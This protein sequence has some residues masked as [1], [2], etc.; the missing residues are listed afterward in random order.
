MRGVHYTMCYMYCEEQQTGLHFLVVS[1]G[2]RHQ[3][4]EN[5]GRT[6]PQSKR[7]VSWSY[8]R[9]NCPA[10]RQRCSPPKICYLFFTVGRY[11]LADDVLKSGSEWERKSRLWTGGDRHT[12]W[13]AC[14]RW[15]AWQLEK[16]VLPLLPLILCSPQRRTDERAFN[17]F[18]FIRVSTLTR[19]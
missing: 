4:F 16:P 11:P 17:F 5:N 13:R 12:W 1:T 2:C 9:L 3:T 8:G 18:K 14:R 10:S 15:S 7:D 6:K 19:R